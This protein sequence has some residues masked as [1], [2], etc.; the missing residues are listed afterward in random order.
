L[1]RRKLTVNVPRRSAGAQSGMALLQLQSANHHSQKQLP[2]RSSD[3]VIG[4]AVRRENATSDTRAGMLTME[5][6]LNGVR[7]MN[8]HVSA[9][10]ATRNGN[11]AI[12][13]SQMAVL[14]LATLKKEMLASGGAFAV[15]KIVLDIACNRWRNP[16]WMGRKL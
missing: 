14:L 7:M 13:T 5:T 10:G 9:G 8:D 11:I 15:R 16:S 12:V 2:H 4:I 1:L 3:Q 6:V